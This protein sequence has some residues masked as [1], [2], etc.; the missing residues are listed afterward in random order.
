MNMNTD[1]TTTKSLTIRRAIANDENEINQ[2]VMRSKSYWPYPKDYIEDCREVLKIDTNYISQWPVY[3]A[4]I[5]NVKAGVCAI[6]P[7]DNENRLDHLW[8][9]P[10]AIR[11]GVGKK[12]LLHAIEEAKKLNWKSFRLAAD[13]YARDFYL[14]MGGKQI[15]TVQSRIKPDLFLPHIEFIF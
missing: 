10:T 4:E 13:P 3:V 12:L 8:I 5:N 1:T 7:V 9:D 15:G 11:T 2:L 6:K 14:K